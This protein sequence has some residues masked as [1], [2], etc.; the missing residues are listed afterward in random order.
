MALYEKTA[1]ELSVLLR[2]GK[3]SST[4][5]TESVLARI[6]AVEDKIGSYITV[7]KELALK[8]ARA[9]DAKRAAGEMLHPLAGI[10]LGV[11]DNICTKGVATTCASRMLEN[12]VPPY[13]A[14][15]VD[16]LEVAGTVMLGKLNL[17]EF[18][19]GS[20]CETSYFKKTHNPHNTDC[21][22]GG[23]SGGSAAALA[24]GEAT[25][26]LGSDTGGSVRLPAS[27]C[28]VVGLKP[29]YG[30][31]S[32]YGAVA[33]ASSLEQISPMARSVEDVA[34]LLSALVGHDPQDTT[35]ARRQYPDFTAGLAGGAKGLRIGVPKEYFGEGISPEVAESVMAAV[36]LLEK[37]GASVQEVSLPSTV[38]ALSAYYVISS[39]EASS[40]LARMD[41]VRYGYRAQNCDT[42]DELF[43]RSRT[44]GFGDEVKRR[45]MLGTNVLSS[46]Y[47]NA[48]YKRAKLLQQRIVGEFTD[49][50]STCDVLIA[51]TAPTPA[52]RIGENHDDPLK[53]YAMDICTVT[54]NIAGLPAISVPSGKSASGLPIGMQI[55]G[56]RFGEET[57]LRTAYHY[58]QAVGGFGPLPQLV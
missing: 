49:V 14:T 36:R 53:M 54:V 12:Y 17:D 37:E 58:Q 57:I 28:G 16:K 41:G 42:I 45:I 50:L 51:P 6:D 9:V 23:S 8:Q 4:E 13:N 3:C 1:T 32:R 52:I 46:G 7:T 43:E 34:L 25:L 20:S 22:P 21:V 5:I 48:Y 24:A 27:Y 44:E 11:K 35:S 15:V 33:F 38:Y 19:M 40:N 56:G 2:E 30:A 47:Y 55:I 10:P 29:T 31:V 18:A 26:T 39:A